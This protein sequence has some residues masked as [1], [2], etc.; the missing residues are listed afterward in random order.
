MAI[1]AEVT[2]N[3][4]I[5]DRRLRHNEYIQFSDQQWPKHPNDCP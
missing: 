4:P 3:E 2:E 1:F 5:D